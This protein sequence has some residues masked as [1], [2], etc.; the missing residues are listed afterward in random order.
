[1]LAVTATWKSAAA[2]GGKPKDPACVL[3]NGQWVDGPNVSCDAGA[4]AFLTPMSALTSL[5]PATEQISIHAMSEPRAS[6]NACETDGARADI[7]IARHAA[8]AA[9]RRV[10]WFIC[11]KKL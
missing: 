5:M 2:A 11:M 8:Q 3:Q 6:A 4:P 10:K 1:M 7:R 9:N